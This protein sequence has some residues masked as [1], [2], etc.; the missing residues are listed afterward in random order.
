[1]ASPD[2]TPLERIDAL[3]RD[4]RFRYR[5]QPSL[6]VLEL[7]DLVESEVVRL[8]EALQEALQETR[9]GARDTM[10]RNLDAALVA[11]LDKPCDCPPVQGRE[12][13]PCVVHVG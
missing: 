11:S 5:T 10:L 7:C 6:P 12:D 2:K 3:I 9:G 8:Q 4:C 13:E 1:V